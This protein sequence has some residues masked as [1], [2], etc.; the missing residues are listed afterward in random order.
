MEEK[1][2][3]KSKGGVLGY[4]IFVF[5]LNTFGLGFCY[6]FLRFVAAYYFLFSP[7]R[8]HVYNYFKQVHKYTSSKA[9][10][11]VYKTYYVFGQTLLDKVAVFSGAK[12]N[13]TIE[14]EGQEHMKLLRDQKKACILIS[15]HM[16]N[17]EVAGNMLE[18]HDLTFNILLY[19]NEEQQM[20]EYMDTVLKNKN[21]KMIT[22]KEDNDMAFLVDLHKAFSNNEWVVMH[23]D[24]FREGAPTLEKD[25]FGRKAKFPAGP[26][27]LA[28]KFGVPVIF[29]FAF[30]ETD[31]HYHFYASPPLEYPRSRNEA[32]TD[33]VVLE[34][35]D[36]YLAHVKEMVKKYPTQWFNFY[37]FW[38]S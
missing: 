14:H 2:Q 21:Y 20:K 6:F 30:K 11:Y 31:K 3:G 19:D 35:S 1:W 12:T 24:R 9:R 23:G 13:F 29:A 38:E 5:F 25:F 4:K 22:L 34:L 18:M 17:W 8:K 32:D 7:T 36:K 16:G 27:I 28:A 33:K 26:F 37:D 15:A 10:R